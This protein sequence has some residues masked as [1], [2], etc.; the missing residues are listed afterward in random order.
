MAV[1][2]IETGDCRE[3][4]KKYPDNF[5]DSLMTSPPYSGHRD[6]DTEPL[7]WDA[8]VG[9][10]HDWN[11]KTY[12]GQ[13]GGK[14]YK[15]DTVR[16]SHFDD[17]AVSFCSKCGAMNGSL[18]LEPNF[19][20]YVKHL[21]DI[22]DLIKPK[23][24]QTGSIFVNIGDTY[25]GSGTQQEKSMSTGKYLVDGFH[26]I[27][28]GI[29]SRDK[30][31]DYPRKSL[32]LVP[33]RFAIEM[34]NRGWVLRNENIWWKRNSM[35][36]SAKDRFTVDYEKVFFFTKSNDIQY[37]TNQKTLQLVVKQPNGI[38]G[39]ENVDYE[40][41]PCT[42]CQVIKKSTA[43]TGLNNK[44]PYQQNNP[45]LLRIVGDTKIPPE[46][47]E[48]VGSPRARYNRTEEQQSC[49]RCGGSGKIKT[50]LWEGH[51]YFYEPQYE[52]YTEQLDR[53]GGNKV[54]ANGESQWDNGTG[55]ETYRDRNLRPNSLGRMPRT[56]WDVTT[57][58][59]SENHFAS[60][61]IELCR[62]PILSS[63][64]LYVC[65]KCGSP[66]ERIMHSVTLHRTA[67]NGCGNG[68]LSDGCCGDSIHQ[69][70]GWSDCGCNV[71]FESGWVLDPFAGTFTTGEFCRKNNRNAVGIELQ[72]LYKKMAVKRARLDEPQVSSME[73]TVI[74]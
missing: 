61:P 52:P 20:L 53:W 28:N 38:N 23:I 51:D 32:C 9:C 11:I 15:Q 68:E 7:I 34:V 31:F 33:D 44:I 21:C 59:Y 6:Y 22:F 27:C 29:A 37:W 74:M 63:C 60:Y 50:S 17:V 42:R 55:Q 5:F 57:S 70:M 10:E 1:Q 67:T 13:S 35:P 66:R 24:K 39:I 12:K 41:I 47:S 56:V 25:W 43:N 19:N 71:G 3:I 2:K 46:I 54:V 72:P 48:S 64:P 4:I 36:S 16:G 69:Q 18:G 45:H 62:L 65:K 40:L 8:K 58:G 49:T 26:S 14:G 73:N 30:S